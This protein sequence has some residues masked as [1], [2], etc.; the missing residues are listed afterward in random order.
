MPL[1]RPFSM[2]RRAVV[3]AVS[4]SGTPVLMPARAS[5]ALRMPVIDWLNIK[6]AALWPQAGQKKPRQS[7]RS[8]KHKRSK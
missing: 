6:S 4:R 7:P 8:G 2:I 1:C 5:K 3:S